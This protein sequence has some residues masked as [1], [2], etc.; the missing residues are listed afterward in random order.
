MIAPLGI[1]ASSLVSVPTGPAALTGTPI[2]LALGTSA[3]PGAQA[4]TVPGD[5]QAVVVLWAYWGT[6]DGQGIL[7]LGSNFASTF[8]I[9]ELN[10]GQIVANA[11]AV[12]VAYA[13]VTSTGSKTITPTWDAAPSYGPVFMLAWIKGIN[14]G[15]WVRATNN[16][17]RSG[18]TTSSAA[19][20]SAATDLVLA[21]DHR[22]EATSPGTEAGWTS[23]LIQQD[24]QGASGRLRTADSPGASTTTAT[25]QNLSWSTISI[26]SIKSA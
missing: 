1:L 26:I 3:T 11:A 7:S 13:T 21:L 23:H 20:S 2:A 5:A 4:V 9:A 25:A 15:D 22:A 24:I 17:H 18:G 16:D 6:A 19:V 14:T 12:G 8:T 10:G